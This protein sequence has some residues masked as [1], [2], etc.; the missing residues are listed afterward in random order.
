MFNRNGIFI[1]TKNRLRLLQ[2]GLSR[3]MNADYPVHLVDDSN[4]Q[5]SIA[6]NKGLCDKHGIY[7][8][9]KAEQARFLQNIDNKGYNSTPFLKVLGDGC[10][11]LGFARNHALLLCSLNKLDKALFLDDDILIENQS[12]IYKIFELLQEYNIVGTQITGMS[13]DSILGHIATTLGFTFERMYSGGCLG[14]KTRIIENYFINTYNEDWIWQYMQTINCKKTEFGQAWQEPY[15]PFENYHSKI[16][17]QE[18]GESIIDVFQDAISQKDLSLLEDTF[19]WEQQLKERAKYLI[20]LKQASQRKNE[21]K[22]A[23]IIDWLQKNYPS[24]TPKEAASI[25]QNYYFH[26]ISFKKLYNELFLS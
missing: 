21:Y 9:G 24:L 2:H 18:Q 16:L 25:F 14:F 7:Y 6:E 17:F 5:E 3:I 1:F 11:N 12:F 4:E 10:W 22:L 15:D 8:Y 26:R 20:E 13:D 23:G 19:F